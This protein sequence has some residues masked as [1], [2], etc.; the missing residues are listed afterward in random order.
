[1]CRNA[2]HPFLL[3]TAGYDVVG[4]LRI[5]QFEGLDRHSGKFAH[6]LEM[7]HLVHVEGV[8]L[9]RQVHSLRLN[10]ILPVIIEGI[11][12]PGESRHIAPGLAGQIIVDIPDIVL[13]RALHRLVHIAGTT[14]VGG[15]CQ[16][17]VP[18]DC[19]G[20][21]Q[22]FGS[23]FHRLNRVQPFVHKGIDGQAIEFRSAVHKLPHTLCA[24]PGHS[25]ILEH[26]LDDRHSPEL[27]RYAV[28]VE[29]FLENGEKV[30]AQTDDPAHLFGHL[31]GVK[32]DVVLNH[33]IESQRYE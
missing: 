4:V 8:H 31:F 25:V 3:R 26:R 14:V 28:T 21:T 20:V 12:G 13:A 32:Y 24:H 7:Q 33:I 11:E 23:R 18:E 10:A 19:I 22:V 30:I 15:D 9:G 6:L 2:E 27:L 29:C 1:M 16:L 17:P 5:E